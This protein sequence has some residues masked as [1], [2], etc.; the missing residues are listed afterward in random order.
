M[1]YVISVTF[2]AWKGETDYIHEVNLER[3][4]QGKGRKI[5]ERA[6]DVSNFSWLKLREF[7]GHVIICIATGVCLVSFCRAL[8]P[9]NPTIESNYDFLQEFF[10]EVAERFPD[11]YVH[12]G[13]DEV[14]FSCW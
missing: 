5:M 12:L 4:R 11:N 2:D 8:G 6:Y 14:P 7:A 10:K 9:I 13:G 3:T 1:R